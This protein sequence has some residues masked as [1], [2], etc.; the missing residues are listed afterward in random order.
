MTLY[1]ENDI[2]IYDEQTTFHL[3][4]QQTFFQIS[5]DF[6]YVDNLTL[7]ESVQVTKAPLNIISAKKFK[8][9]KNSKR[10][11]IQNLQIIYCQILKLGFISKIQGIFLIQFN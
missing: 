2:N 11:E 1:I 9:K 3:W 4:Q 10:N 6:T 7:D 8:K 5:G